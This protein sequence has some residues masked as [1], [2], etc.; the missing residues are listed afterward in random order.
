MH[1]TV[2][3]AR[4]PRKAGRYPVKTNGKATLPKELLHLDLGQLR[5]VVE[6]LSGFLEAAAE[7]TAVYLDYKAE[8]AGEY[9][10]G[11]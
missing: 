11:Y 3:G 1:R 9:G 5:D 7:Q 8:M 6:R 10:P 2:L 4:R